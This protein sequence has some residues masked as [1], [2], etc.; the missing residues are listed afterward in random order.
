MPV[1][2]T[3]KFE[4]QLC[5]AR[6]AY[7]EGRTSPLDDA[8]ARGIACGTCDGTARRGIPFSCFNFEVRHLRTLRRRLVVD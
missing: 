4:Y 1:D 7:R 5:R 8:H 6:V 3:P 2:G